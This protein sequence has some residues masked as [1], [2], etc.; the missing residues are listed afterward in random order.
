VQRQLQHVRLKGG[1]PTIYHRA[2]NRENVIFRLH[3]SEGLVSHMYR[4]TGGAVTIG[5]GHAIPNADAACKLAWQLGDAS[6]PD[7]LVRGD[8]QRVAWAGQ[9][10]LAARYANLSTCRMAAEKI[11]QLLAADIDSFSAQLTAL[12]EGWVNYPEPAQEAL[13]DMAYNLG[14]GGLKKFTK[15]LAACAAGDWAAAA[16]ESRRRGIPDWRNDEAAALFR[17]ASIP[18]ET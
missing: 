6:A 7:A 3:R 14:V 1:R 8:Y 12:V 15:L 2:M 10:M 5:V 9:G 17:S 11:E 18:Q 16:G 4:C 13:F